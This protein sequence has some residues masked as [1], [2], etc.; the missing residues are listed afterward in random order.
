MAPLWRGARPMRARLEASGEPAR[1]LAFAA[2]L[3]RTHR[4]PVPGRL[5]V[6]PSGDGAKLRLSASLYTFHADR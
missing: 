1:V 2:D 4:A 6:E 5:T 3:F